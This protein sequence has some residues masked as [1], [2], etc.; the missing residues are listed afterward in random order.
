MRLASLLGLLLFAPVTLAQTWTLQNSPTAADLSAVV[1]IDAT[2]AVAVGDGGTLLATTDGGRTWTALSAPAGLDLE[3]VDFSAGGVGIIATDDGVVMRTTDGVTFT[4]VGTGVGD[5]RGVAWGTDDVVFAAGREASGARSTDGGQTWTAFST[6]ALNRTEGVA[7][8]GAD[9]LWAVGREG[10]I[11]FSSDGGQTWGAQASGTADDLNAVQVLS[12]Q[13]GY[14]VGSGDTVLK[15]T[16]GGQTWMSVS[17]GNAGGEALHFLDETT[18]WV[19]D[20]AGEVWFTSDG[21]TAWQLQPT[22]TSAELNG[23]SFADATHGWAVG[24]AGTIIAFGAPA[25]DAEET[26][27][28]ERVSL[29]AASPNPFATATTL[30]YALAEGGPVR[31]AVYDVLGREVAVLAAGKVA[32]GVHEASFDAHDVPAGIYFVRLTA[33]G[34]SVTRRVTRTR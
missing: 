31:L 1:A 28:V 22:P 8:V 20:N 3:G 33:E 10:E 7:A 23:V 5:L 18:G 9:R 11:R 30:R 19:V 29:D 4:S 21:G 15:T 24:A 25:T 12:E 13:V 16:D 6:G 17:D 32:A 34:A 14:I 26:A 27:A 2:T